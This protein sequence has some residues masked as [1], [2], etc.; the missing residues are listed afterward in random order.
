MDT[1]QGHKF[2]NLLNISYDNRSIIYIIETHVRRRKCAC[3]FGFYSRTNSFSSFTPENYP[4]RLHTWPEIKRAFSFACC[5]RFCCRCLATLNTVFMVLSLES[6][7]FLFQCLGCIKA[8][9]ITSD[10]VKTNQKR[11]SISIFRKLE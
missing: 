7:V 5:R 1:N 6:F 10:T 2:L 8:E 4:D 9:E 11:V 3:F